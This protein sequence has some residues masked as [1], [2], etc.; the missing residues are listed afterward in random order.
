VP[1]SDNLIRGIAFIIVID[2]PI[3]GLRRRP[4]GSART[5]AAG[6]KAVGRRKKRESQP[7]A[8]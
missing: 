6:K 4:T 5:A 7:G 3:I 1:G 8:V 2:G